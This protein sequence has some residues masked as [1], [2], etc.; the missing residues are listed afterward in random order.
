MGMTSPPT[1]KARA[2]A[3]IR[4]VG[5]QTDEILRR[6]ARDQQETNDVILELIS[7]S[8]FLFL[9]KYFTHRNWWSVWAEAAVLVFSFFH[10]VLALY[11]A[12]SALTGRGLLVVAFDRLSAEPLL[13]ILP[14]RQHA[15]RVA[16]GDGRG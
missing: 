1:A 14:V 15:L 12:E 2:L 9:I 16:G 6:S 5:A 11:G 13:M 10:V 4:R 7:L 8:I 3:E